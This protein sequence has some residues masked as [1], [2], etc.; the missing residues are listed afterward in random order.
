[1]SRYGTVAIVALAAVFFLIQGAFFTVDQTELALVVQLGKPVREI[2]DPG[3]NFKVPF[4]QNV[5]RFE[6]RLLLYDAAPTEIITKDKKSLV[7]DNYSRWKI[8]EPLKF[9]KTVFNEIGAQSRLDD[10]IYAQLREE[11]GKHT[12]LEIVSEKRADIMETVTATSDETAGKYGI[13]IYDVR[14]K[15]ADL[16]KENEEHVFGRMKAERQRQAKKYRSEGEE[17]ALKLRAQADKEKTIIL[18]EAYKEA[19]DIKGEGDA[20]AIRIYADAYERD[21]EFFGF[22][23]S[24]EVYRKAMKSGTKLVISS[25]SKVFEYLSEG[26]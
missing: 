19:Q 13:E 2:D 4:I 9:Y 8:V 24:L 10:I 1:M 16:P 7:V 6:K 22:V 26:E 18:A 21:P 17:A 14:I 25:D 11:L 3:L 15:R 12:L 5:I 23:K 20:E